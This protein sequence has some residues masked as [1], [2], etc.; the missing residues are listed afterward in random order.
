MKISIFGLG[1]V[2]LVTSAFFLKNEYKVYGIDISKKK[3]SNLK[4]GT[5]VIK[6]PG[7]NKILSDSI[8][9]NTFI[10][11]SNIIDG[12]S[13]TNISIICVGTPSKS[14]G[15]I[16]LSSINSVLKEIGVY[17]KNKKRFHI[18][19]IRSTVL[20]NTCKFKF[21]P[22][23]EKY[24]R[25]KNGEHFNLFFNPE[26]LREGS[27]LNDFKNP[28]VIVYGCDSHKGKNIIRNISKNI[29][30]KTFFTDFQTAETI[31]YMNNVWHAYKIT[32][33]NEFN[34]ISKYF[35]VNNSILQKI[36][37]SD[38]KLNI[39]TKYLQP[40]LPFGGSCLPK[41]VSALNSFFVSKKIP[42]VMINN[43]N[44]SNNLQIKFQ[45]QKLSYLKN[46]NILCL[47]YSFKS[48]SDDCRESP[49]LKILD[50][51]KMKADKNIYL[52]DKNVDLDNLYGANSKY[53]EKMKNKIKFINYDYLENLKNIN[54]IIIFNNFDFYQN[55]ISEKFKYIDNKNVIFFR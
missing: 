35:N 15:S 19:I 14:S 31:K 20:P 30:G 36:F 5:S 27:A 1:Y 6:E 24:S 9:K 8:I 43:I 2:G 28:S 32:F 25:K 38:K 45:S 47:G 44:K 48:N 50:N 34:L 7:V 13:K 16:N 55:L 18:L 21:I 46:H 11:S 10:P 54:K 3:I 17:L 41:D 22:L 4:K 12:L 29:K 37:L 42:L 40:G 33:A 53:I 51:I 52:Y 23:L 39:S 49:I 26:F